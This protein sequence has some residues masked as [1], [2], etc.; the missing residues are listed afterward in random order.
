[1]P[2]LGVVDEIEMFP[3]FSE[4]LKAHLQTNWIFLNGLRVY[5][6]L[7]VHVFIEKSVYSD[8]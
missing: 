6:V 3:C 7:E 8:R 4:L 2:W 1:M 5:I